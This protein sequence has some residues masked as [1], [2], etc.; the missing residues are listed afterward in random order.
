MNATPFEKAPTDPV[1]PNG[2]AANAAWLQASL[3]QKTSTLS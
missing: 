1:M 3:G 2:K